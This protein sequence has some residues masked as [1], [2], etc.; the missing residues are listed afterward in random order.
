MIFSLFKEIC[1]IPDQSTDDLNK[2]PPSNK[3]LVYDVKNI[4]QASGIKDK[5]L[6]APCLLCPRAQRLRTSILEL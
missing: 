5:H 4:V 1:L 3:R 2:R 6:L